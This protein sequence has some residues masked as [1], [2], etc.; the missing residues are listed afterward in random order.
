MGVQW[1]GMGEMNSSHISFSYLL[2]DLGQVTSLGQ[3]TCEE[4]GVSR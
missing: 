3:K 1:D 4:D 2:C